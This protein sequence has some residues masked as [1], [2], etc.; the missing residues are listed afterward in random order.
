MAPCGDGEE[1]DLF[2]VIDDL[3]DGIDGMDEVQRERAREIL[4]RPVPGKSGKC[5]QDWED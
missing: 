3:F 2:G 5:P 1:E 4:R